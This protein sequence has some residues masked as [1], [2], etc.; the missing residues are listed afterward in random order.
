MASTEEKEALLERSGPPAQGHI[1]YVCR[2]CNFTKTRQ[3]QH[4]RRGGQALLDALMAE[5]ARHDDVP[6][7]IEAVDCLCVCV[8]SCAAA[9]MAPDKYTYTFGWL[10]P[11]RSAAELIECARLFAASDDGYVSYA[12][13][14]GST[15]RL[16]S[17]VP[18]RGNT[19]HRSQGPANSTALPATPAAPTG[20]AGSVARQI[21]ASSQLIDVQLT[22]VTYAAPG[23]NLYELRRPEN[24]PLPEIEPGSHI[25]LHL[26]SGHVR[27]YSLINDEPNPTRYLIGVKRDPKGR[28]GSL[29]IHDQLRVGQPMSIGLPRN[30]FPLQEQAERSI[31]FAGGIGITPI[32][33]MIGRLTALGRPWSLFYSCRSRSEALFLERLGADPSVRL[34]FD[35][36][37]GGRVLNFADVLQNLPKE[38]HLYCCGPPPMLSAFLA[39]AERW[40]QDRVHVERFSS[41]ESAT[42]SKS[43]VIELARSNLELVVPSGKTIL[44]TLRE[45]G[46]DVP[47]SCEQGFC[48]SCAVRVLKGDPDHRDIALTDEQRLAND[49]IMICCSGSK[50][51]RLVLDL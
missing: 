4:G 26:P 36:E 10:D 14:P 15:K 1:L 25:D 51:D 49:T 13:R 11:D 27:Q 44:A 38:A 45:A 43:F 22:A 39:A 2:S 20:A 29:F 33:S 42:D 18:P 5:A 9:L 21:P 3:E 40:P 46:F 30:N 41:G 8:N 28:G 17:R 47:S 6:V 7:T 32:L 16:V 12:D 24:Q 23:V 37:N 31:F 19:R 48:G 50:S 35:D 34:H